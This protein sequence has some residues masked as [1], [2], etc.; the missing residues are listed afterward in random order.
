[1]KVLLGRRRPVLVGV[2]GSLA[3]SA[4]V[5]VAAVRAG[6]GVQDLPGSPPDGRAIALGLAQKYGDLVATAV[7]RRVTDAEIAE[8]GIAP[9]TEGARGL[10]DYYTCVKDEYGYSETPAR[11][12]ANVLGYRGMGPDRLAASVHLGAHHGSDMAGEIDRHILRIERRG[13]QWLI[14]EDTVDNGGIHGPDDETSLVPEHERLPWQVIG[15]HGKGP[16]RPAPATPVPP[17]PDDVSAVEVVDDYEP[18]RCGWPP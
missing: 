1:V 18:G 16:R 9:S 13:G 4:T 8:A 17:L 6:D 3:V 2:L 5:A 15:G 11:R 14:V 7:R 12:F 10:L